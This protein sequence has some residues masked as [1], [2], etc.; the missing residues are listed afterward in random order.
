[1]STERLKWIDSR[2]ESLLDTL[3]QLSAINSGTGNLSGLHDTQSALHSLFSPLADEVEIDDSVSVERTDHWGITADQHYGKIISF[4]KRKTAPFQILLC[5]HMD[6]VFPKEHSFQS[7]EKVDEHILKG[8]GVADMKGGI[9][10]MLT[11]LEAFESSPGNDAIG[12]KVILSSDEETGSLG[13][14]AVLESAAKRSHVGMIYEPALADGTLAGARKGSGNFTLV[15][16]GKSAHAGREFSKGRNAIVALS[17]F[18]NQIAALS[19]LEQDITV[20]VA[21]IT[22]GT[23]VN[24][25]PDLAV[26]QFN[27]RC[28]RPEKLLDIQHK[29]STIVDAQNAKNDVRFTLSGGFT[30]PPKTISPGTQLLMDWTRE[31]GESL[32]TAVR[33]RDTGGC[34]DGNNLAAAGLPNVDTLGVCGANIHTDQE[35]MLIDSLTERAKL[36][37]KLLGKI[38]SHGDQLI[39]LSSAGRAS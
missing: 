22:G 20:N 19:N 29:L 33:F 17:A 15:A 8:P 38:A 10:V 7:P 14:S 6:T 39:E 18:I 36:S 32:N 4:S 35:Y 9:L 1:M 28:P 25:V 21:R 3:M 12:W 30:R 24:V 16:H 31:C 13:S 2:K 11:A 27:V 37:Y 34:C 5:G 23:A 26:C